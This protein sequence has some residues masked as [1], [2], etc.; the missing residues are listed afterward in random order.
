MDNHLKGYLYVVLGLLLT[1]ISF[2]LTTIAIRNINIPSAAF[3]IFATGLITSTSIL[4]AAGKVREAKTIIIKY[5]KPVL[6]IGILNA[7][8]AFLWLSSLKLIGPSVTSF[9]ARFGTIF[10]IIMSVVFLKERFNKLELIGTVIMIAGAF[11]IS[12]NGGDFIIKGV[13]IALIFS[14]TFSTW[15]FMSKFYIKHISPLVMTVVGKVDDT[16][17]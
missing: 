7:V 1:I 8:S 2:I 17:N 4:I 10:T 3:F 11:V 6:V 16:I 5:W 14:L 13:I 12:Y 9:L 15:Q